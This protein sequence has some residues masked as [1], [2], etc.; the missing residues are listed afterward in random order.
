MKCVGDKFEKLE[1]DLR[2]LQPRSQLCHRHR[3][4]FD[5]IVTNITVTVGTEIK[6]E[7]TLPI[8]L[9][10]SSMRTTEHE[11]IDDDV[12]ESVAPKTALIYTP[13]KPG[14][15]VANI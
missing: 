9:I 2:I 6:T 5:E 12:V 7:F 11:L 3:N 8:G 15:T 4:G 14:A 1:T 13:A 10:I